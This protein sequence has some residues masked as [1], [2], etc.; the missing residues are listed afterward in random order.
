MRSLLTAGPADL[1]DNDLADLYAFPEVEGSWVR[2]IFVAAAD[3]A[4]QGGDLAS[5][6]LSGPGDRRIFGL[7]R[8][9]C[10]AVLVGAG[11]ARVEGYRPVRPSEV[12]L[13]LRRRLGLAPVPAIAVVSRSLTFDPILLGG[14]APTI[15]VTTEDARE[16]AVADLAGR[17]EVV[18]SGI[19]DVDLAGALDTLAGLG[20]RRVLCEGGPTLLAQLVAAD[21]LDDLCLT[22]APMLVAGDRQRILRG[23]D[24]MPVRRLRLAHLLQDED[25]IFVRYLV[26]RAA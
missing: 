8:S 9:L 26:D 15:V 18:R 14:P 24:L 21:R 25:E 5:A 17:A 3:G 1:G 7:Q 6:S 13:D 20:H 2:A 23:P 22:I 16:P 11:T 12:D 10:D 4:A 19:G